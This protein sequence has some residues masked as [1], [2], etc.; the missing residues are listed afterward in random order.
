MVLSGLAFALA[1]AYLGLKLDGD[2]FPVGNPTV[3]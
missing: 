1:L 2:Q 3:V